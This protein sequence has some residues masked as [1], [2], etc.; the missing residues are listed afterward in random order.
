MISHAAIKLLS[1]LCF[2]DTTVTGPVPGRSICICVCMCV[3]VC[4]GSHLPMRIALF[5]GWGLYDNANFYR[6]PV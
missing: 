4:E 1:F 6:G 3:C 2:E 5:F